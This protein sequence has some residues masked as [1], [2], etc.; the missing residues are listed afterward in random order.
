M[1]F[2]SYLAAVIFFLP[3]GLNVAKA[4]TGNDSVINGLNWTLTLHKF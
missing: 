3:L 1:K 2:L 4:E